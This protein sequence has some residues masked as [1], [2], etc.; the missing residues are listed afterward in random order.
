[1]PSQPSHNLYIVP[2]QARSVARFEK[3]TEAAKVVIARNWYGGLSIQAVAKEAKVST[4]SIYR[5]FPDRR[6]FVAFMFDEFIELQF[7][8]I[9]DLI[10][11]AQ[12]E[13]DWRKSI[14]TYSDTLKLYSSE[15]QHTY[16]AQVALKVDK[17]LQ[18]YW[19]TRISE[20]QVS[21]ISLFKALGA[22]GD[23]HKFRAVTLTTLLILDAQ[24]LNYNIL[25]D[26]N[27]YDPSSSLDN[28]LLNYLQDVFV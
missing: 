23:D 1:M 28:A 17:T 15:N 12:T 19:F 2:V 5:Y 18:A 22:N 4:T 6:G 14:N 8:Q 9:Q 26:R 3:I 16:P 13:K 7:V 25:R 27:L 20:L 21:L 11:Q 10:K 24:M